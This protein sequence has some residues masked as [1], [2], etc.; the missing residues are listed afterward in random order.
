[1]AET[2]PRQF[3]R[4]ELLSVVLRDGFGTIYRAN[5]THYDREVWVRVLDGDLA[6]DE[7]TSDQFQRAARLASGLSHPNVPIVHEVGEADGLPFLS[8][9]PAEG[10]TLAERLRAESP[11]FPLRAAFIV[12]QITDALEYL[13]E[14][15]M[16]HG[17]LQD[18]SIW[19][20]ADDQVMLL[21]F[22]MALGMHAPEKDTEALA[23]LAHEM[24]VGA[25]FSRTDATMR[26]PGIPW[27]RAEDRLGAEMWAIL[28]RGV[29]HE[30]KPY[31]GFKEFRDDF[32]RAAETA[33]PPPRESR[34]LRL[35]EQRGRARALAQ[36]AGAAAR[37]GQ[38]ERVSDLAGHALRLNPKD[39]EARQW[40]SRAMRV[41]GGEAPETLGPVLR[42]SRRRRYPI[43]LLLAAAVIVAG[44]GGGIWAL[45]RPREAANPT[46]TI[47]LTPRPTQTAALP[48][49]TSVPIVV[50][51]DTPIPT[52]V[53]PTATTAPAT[54]TTA[55]TDTPTP[56]P[57]TDTP[58]RAPTQTPVPPSPTPTRAL[59]PAPT[60]LSPPNEL[61]FEPQ[62]TI[63]LQWSSVGPLADDEWYVVRV[64]HPL[65]EEVGVTRDT[66]WQ[67]PTYVW[68]LRPLSGRFF[69]SVSVR[70]R[71]SDEIP[72]NAD[73][74]PAAGAESAARSFVWL[75]GTRTPTPAPTPAP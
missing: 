56:A 20:S 38:W 44:I 53:P 60:L 61:H 68:L 3:G 32:V 30:G 2:L 51:T 74:W 23:N 19:L 14:R 73:L 28:M 39:A 62:Q 31:A 72:G 71:I 59:H 45:T 75:A 5:D 48:S 69:W 43:G 36:Q 1:M 49:A 22:G 57:P 7:R 41:V 15:W 54:A 10:I 9:R 17:N 46:A 42:K 47:T 55:P 67:V 12:S 37:L 65:G 35:R 13:N 4:Y 16:S 6:S 63:V 64:P 29:G 26:R 18:H 8:F 34:R 21:D 24:V 58:T 33:G 50:P 25:P 70:V 11:I 27:R 40:L 66:R 52:R